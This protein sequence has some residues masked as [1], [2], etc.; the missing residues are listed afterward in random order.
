[1]NLQKILRRQ[2]KVG[3]TMSF[4]N[5]LKE[6]IIEF[7]TRV[8]NSFS[9]NQ[10]SGY[11]GLCIVDENGKELKNSVDYIIDG[12]I[13]TVKEHINPIGLMMHA[14]LA[15]MPLEKPSYEKFTSNNPVKW[16][17]KRRRK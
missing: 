5:L 17:N 12:G 8:R 11:S 10:C 4:A 1:M 16:Y 13:L 6:D 15:P 9:N 7:K 2:S 3:D 14:R